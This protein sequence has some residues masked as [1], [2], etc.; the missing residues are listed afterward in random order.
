MASEGR[1]R[2]GDEDQHRRERQPLQRH[3][4]ELAGE[5]EQAEQDEEGD[6]GDPAEALVEGDDGA[7]GGDAGAEPSASAV[8]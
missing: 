7:A 8:R 5:D 6:L 1:D 3:V 2:A 4:V